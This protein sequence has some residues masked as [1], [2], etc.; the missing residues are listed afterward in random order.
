METTLK[1]GG[2]AR[3]Y[4]LASAILIYA[5]TGGS[6]QPWNSSNHVAATVH[7][8]AQADGRP[9]IQPGQPVSVAALE[10]LM[11]SLGRQTGAQAIPENLLS[12]GMDRMV[13]WSRA[14]R[15]RIW[16]NASHDQ[17]G[18]KPLSGKFVY[19]PALLFVAHTHNLSVYALAGDRRPV[20]KTKI[21]RAPYW[22]LQNGHMCNGNLTLPACLPEN[23]AGFEAAFFNSEFTHGG[24]GGITRHAGGHVGLWTALAARKTKPDEKY[25]RANLISTSQTLDQIYKL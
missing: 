8:V 25:W 19:H 12:L 4:R 16:F 23:I 10:R 7:D 24:G 17:T 1:F 14:S 3:D 5:D 9:V 22:N 18:L 2:Q 13:W 21:Y 6:S 20:P 11:Q 15:R